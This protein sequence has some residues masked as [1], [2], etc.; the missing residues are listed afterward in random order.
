MGQDPSCLPSASPTIM[1]KSIR[2]LG[3]ALFTWAGVRA[4]SLGMVPGAEALSIDSPAAREKSLIP[5]IEPTIL[6]PIEPVSAG[7]LADMSTAGSQH[8]AAHAAYP[9]YAAYPV[10]IP[11]AAP[12]ARSAPPQVVYVNAPPGKASDI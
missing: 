12:A 3:L 2:F 8:Y 10:Y 1:S 7:Q 4:V 5:P 9:G 11:V 6:P